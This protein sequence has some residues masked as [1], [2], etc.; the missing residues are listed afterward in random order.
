MRLRKDRP[1]RSTQ[2]GLTGNQFFSADQLAG[3]MK[4]REDYFYSEAWA[5]F[6]AKKIKSTYGQQGFIDAQV[7]ARCTILPEAR[8]D[9]DYEIKEGS[10]YRIGEITV[11]GNTTLQDRTIRRIMDEEGFTL[12][13]WYN[14]DIA[15]GN[16]EGELEK[17]SASLLWPKRP[18]HSDRHRS[19]YPRCL[20]YHSRGSGPGSIMLG[21]GV[22]SD[23]GVIGSISLTQGNFDITDWPDSW[24]ELFTGKAFRGAGQQFRI[25]ASPGTEVSTYSVSFTEPLSV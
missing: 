3:D 9:V 11:V 21:A 4:L 20:G 7:D 25:A 1:I 6:D 16:G 8:V 17:L 5:D 23:S 13:Q 15:R 14:G 12:G 19:Q 2:S 22:A 18:N 10:R 24:S